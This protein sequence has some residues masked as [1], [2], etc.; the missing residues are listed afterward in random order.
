MQR[1]E[2]KNEL[3]KRKPSKEG[4]FYIATAA[5]DT[6]MLDNTSTQGHVMFSNEETEEFYIG[7]WNRGMYFFDVLF[8]KKTTRRLTKEEIEK[9]KKDSLFLK[10]LAP[11][12]FPGLD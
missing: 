7:K 3:K 2:I 11:D 9:F 12:P 8:P 1:E 6:I 5:F 10:E 4:H